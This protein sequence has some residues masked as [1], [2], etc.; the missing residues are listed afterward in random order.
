[1]GRSAVS[2]ILDG[3]SFRREMLRCEPMLRGSL[4]PARTTG[5]TGARHDGG[6]RGEPQPVSIRVTRIC[7]GEGGSWRLVYRHGG[8]GPSAKAPGSW[9][10]SRG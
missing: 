10:G 1:M 6:G 2:A 3:P 9:M 7:R 5:R 4:G 8:F